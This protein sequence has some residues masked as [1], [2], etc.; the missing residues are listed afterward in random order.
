[1]AEEQLVLS[2]LSGHHLLKSRRRRRRSSC[3]VERHRLSIPLL[4]GAERGGDEAGEAGGE[5]AEA[6]PDEDDE[7]PGDAAFR[8]LPRDRGAE[9]LD[10][11]V[12]ARA[13]KKTGGWG[14]W[15]G[16]G[17]KNPMRG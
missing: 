8:A 3:F 13:E 14:G 1:M 17:I 12:E 9:R 6:L 7:R 15:G 5:A 4:K 10:E 11:G 16:H 2:I